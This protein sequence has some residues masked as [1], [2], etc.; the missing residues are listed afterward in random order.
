MRQ[1]SQLASLGK[2]RWEGRDGLN[3]LRHDS[4]PESE[5]SF[6]GVSQMEVMVTVE[7]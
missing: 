7:T 4:L 3:V 6:Q 5:L 2:S 1:N